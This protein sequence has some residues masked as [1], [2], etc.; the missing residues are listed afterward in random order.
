LDS[1]QGLVGLLGSVERC[2]EL[3]GWQVSGVA[4]EALR[5]MPVDPSERRELNVRDGLPRFALLRGPVDQLG[6]V[7]PVHRLRQRVVV[8]VADG[9]DGGDC[10]D[11]GESFTVT[12]ARE[13]AARVRV[14]PQSFEG[15]C[16]IGGGVC[17]AIRVTA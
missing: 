7:E 5:V 11:L 8:A 2:F 1:N 9:A 16:C 4:V 14:A 10:A 12:D 17:P 15:V 3:R 13:L 6:L